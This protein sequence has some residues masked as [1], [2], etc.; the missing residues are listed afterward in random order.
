MADYR[1][2]LATATSILLID[3]PSRDVPETL[4]RHGYRVVANDGPREDEY[5]AYELVDGAV[6]VRS[7]DSAPDMVDIVYAHRPISELGS[8]VEQ[9]R[10]LNARA[11][12]VETGAPQAREMVERAGLLYFD[13]PH[14]PDAVRESL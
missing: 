11:V 2:L 14:L 6:R 5:N 9:A 1:E 12:W 8:I 7:L 10:N 4:A 3:W 13:S